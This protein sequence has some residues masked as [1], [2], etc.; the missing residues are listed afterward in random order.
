MKELAGRNQLKLT[1]NPPQLSPTQNE[2]SKPTLPL[3]SPKSAL[4]KLH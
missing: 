1:F 2:R 4:P 3:R